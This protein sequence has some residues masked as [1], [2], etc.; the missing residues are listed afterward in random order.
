MGCDI[1]FVVEQKHQDKWVGLL[2]TEG[3]FS[4]PYGARKTLPILQF[5]D[6]DYEFF[7]RLAG[8]RRNGPQALGVPEDASDL[9]YMQMTQ[10]DGFGHSHSYCSLRDFVRAKYIVGI[11][12][13]ELAIAT[14]KNEDFAARVLNIRE[15]DYGPLDDYRVVFWFDN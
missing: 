7:G 9:A 4:L 8:V 3:P 15:E 1:H 14:L 2:S 11:G 5:Q 10:W 6:R 12:I 13:T